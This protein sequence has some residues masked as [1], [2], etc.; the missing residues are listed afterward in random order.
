MKP[1]KEANSDP[2]KLW[3]L[4]TTIYSLNNASRSWYLNVKNELTKLGAETCQSDPFVFVW[5]SNAK[6]YGI[7]C[8]HVD[9]FLF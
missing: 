5:H 8:T 9:D 1:P 4:N 7:L 6:L 3:K 2:N